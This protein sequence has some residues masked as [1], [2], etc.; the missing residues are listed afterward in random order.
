MMKLDVYKTNG[1]K[2]GEEVEISDEIFNVQPNDHVVYL[3]VKAYN[4]NQRQGTHKTKERCE[5]S[6]G[7][8][9]PWHQKGRGGARAGSSRSPLWVGGGTV[10]G[11]KPHSYRQKLNKKV[12]SLAKKSALSMKANSEQIMLVEDF[13]FESPKTKDLVKILD[14]LKQSGKKVTLLTNGLQENIYLS[15]RN[16]EKVQVLE[17]NRASIYD[18]LN[19]QTLMIQKSALE[20]LTN[21]IK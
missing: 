18:L 20:L 15:G 6:G 7:G 4:A 9:K 5:V 1:E 16:V 14:A 2:S 12:R 13:T 10:F 8:K 19:N 3:A 17:A 21:T 11:P